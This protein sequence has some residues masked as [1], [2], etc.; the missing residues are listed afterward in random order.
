MRTSHSDAP[1][2]RGKRRGAPQP[3]ADNYETR[4][5]FGDSPKTSPACTTPRFE[6]RTGNKRHKPSTMTATTMGDKGTGGSKKSAPS[7]RQDKR[8]VDQTSVFETP[9]ARSTRRNADSCGAIREVC[10]CLCV[11]V[12]VRMHG[13]LWTRQHV[14]GWNAREHLRRQ[15]CARVA[16]PG[17]QGQMQL[18]TRPTHPPTPFPFSHTPSPAIIARSSCPSSEPVPELQAQGAYKRTRTHRQ[19]RILASRR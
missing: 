5:G 19:Q 3:A 17:A 18:S 15:T 2:T 12:L 14:C 6:S 7:R 1:S 4:D 13:S 11:R 10:V 9:T 8:E 16:C